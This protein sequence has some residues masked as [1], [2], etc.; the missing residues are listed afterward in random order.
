VKANGQEPKR[1]VEDEEREQD[2]PLG[3]ERELEPKREVEFAGPQ[4]NQRPG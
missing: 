2:L 4:Q 3:W 1:E